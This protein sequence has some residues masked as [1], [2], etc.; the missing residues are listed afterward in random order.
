[1]QI[2]AVKSAYIHPK[3][4]KVLKITFF[5]ANPTDYLK[6]ILH[7]YTEIWGGGMYPHR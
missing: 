3:T 7:P 6:C 2:S 5:K 4:I 1:M